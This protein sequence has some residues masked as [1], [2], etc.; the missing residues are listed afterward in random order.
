MKD[1]YILAV[2]I[3]AVTLLLAG[4]ITRTFSD[5]SIGT[6]QIMAAFGLMGIALAALCW[7]YRQ[8]AVRAFRVKSRN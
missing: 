1:D 5:E 2:F 4:T 3:S 6:A 7:T 8:I